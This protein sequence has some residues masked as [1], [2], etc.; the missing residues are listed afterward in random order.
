MQIVE[1]FR[2]NSEHKFHM[3]F[4]LK[5]FKSEKLCFDDGILNCLVA[6]PGLESVTLT[7]WK[8]L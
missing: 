5:F 4:D 6:I 1:T 2:E 7:I 3:A 8:V